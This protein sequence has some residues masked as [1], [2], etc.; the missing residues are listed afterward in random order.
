[1]G[2]QAACQENARST[3][4]WRHGMPDIRKKRVNSIA[5]HMPEARDEH[6]SKEASSSAG[7]CQEEHAQNVQEAYKKHA[8]S[9]PGERKKH[10]RSMP[11]ACTPGACH[12][13]DTRQKH[14]MNKSANRQEGGTQPSMQDN[15][16][17]STPPPRE[18]KKLPGACYQH[19]ARHARSTH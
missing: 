8:S 3:E 11:E 1:M 5:R 18:H 17:M 12:Q 9:P 6:V 7:Q 2:T 10:A 14:A 19:V 15:G 4:A 13:P 16:R